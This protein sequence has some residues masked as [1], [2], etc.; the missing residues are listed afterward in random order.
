MRVGAYSQIMASRFGG[1]LEVE[2]IGA[3]RTPLD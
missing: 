1:G 2:V 3:L